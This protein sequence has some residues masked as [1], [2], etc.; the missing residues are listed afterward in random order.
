M[1]QTKPGA[2]RVVTQAGGHA[3]VFVVAKEPAGQRD[4]S[5]PG[6][7]ENIMQMLQQ[8]KE[9]LLHAAY[10]TAAQDEANVVNHLARR[11]VEARGGVP[12]AVLSKP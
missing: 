8:R 7:R 2:A 6:V 10:V 3:I 4:L 1:L 5:T 12:P 11:I 9:Q